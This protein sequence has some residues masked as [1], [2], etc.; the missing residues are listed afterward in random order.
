MHAVCYW[1]QWKQHIYKQVY[2]SP[3][4]LIYKSVLLFNA[5][6]LNFKQKYM[7]SVVYFSLWQVCS[8]M[9]WCGIMELCVQGSAWFKYQNCHLLGQATV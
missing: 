9:S 2:C 1:L 4:K 3:M 8:L 7:E 5:K 6:G